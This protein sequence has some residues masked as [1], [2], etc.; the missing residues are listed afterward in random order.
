VIISRLRNGK[1]GIIKGRSECPKCHHT[2]TGKDLIPLFS[3]LSTAGKCRYCK[4][5]IPYFYPFLEVTFAVGFLITAYLLSDVTLILEG[6]IEEL[7]RLLFFL[8]FT[9]GTLLYVIYDLMYYEIPDSVLISLIGMS[10]VAL[11]VQNFG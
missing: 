5:K 3:F 2:L 11:L 6:N 4:T 8:F 7:V 10:S 9:F 1:S